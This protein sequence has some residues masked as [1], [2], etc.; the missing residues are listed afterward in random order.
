MCKQV[1]NANSRG[2]EARNKL[3]AY[4]NHNISLGTIVYPCGVF[5]IDREYYCPKQIRNVS[6]DTNSA[7]ISSTARNQYNMC[8]QA[9]S[10]YSMCKDA[11]NYYYY[12]YYFLRLHD[13]WLRSPRGQM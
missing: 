2:K 1:L 7:C 3:Q 11:P 6:H 8:T 10:V 4:S 9:L 12:Y 5:P 13:I